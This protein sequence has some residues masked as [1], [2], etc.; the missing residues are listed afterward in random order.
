VTPQ[1]RKDKAEQIAGILCDH[2]KWKSHGHFI[3]RNTAW[4]ECGL[5]ITH[6]E[7]IQGLDRAMR[8]MWALFY[9]L[10]ES[11]PILKFFISDN[12]CIIRQKQIIKLPVK[13]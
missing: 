13:P 12:Y 3:D 8:R 10:F 9:W 2:G 7:S 1:E 6:S 5:Q 11:T 4:T